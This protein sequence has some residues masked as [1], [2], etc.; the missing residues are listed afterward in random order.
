MK[1]FLAITMT[2][3]IV[4]TMSHQL[5]SQN[6]ADIKDFGITAGGFTNFPANQ[7]YMKDDISAF[8]VAPCVRSGRHEFSAGLLY[9]II[10]K[11]LSFSDNNI[12]PRPGFIAGYKFYILNPYYR[13]NVFI[14][15][16]FEYFRYTG[17]YDV[18]YSGNDVPVQ[19]TETDMYIN[20][21]IGLGY[22]LYFDTGQRFGLYYTLDYLIP[23]TSYK[24]GTPGYTNNSW[25][26]KY[27]WNNLSTHIGLSFKITSL[28]KKVRRLEGNV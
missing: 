8:Y 7:N 17:K 11:G 28:K 18:Y 19:W 1:K 21:V 24:L 25:T 13:E 5:L 14:H 9:P 15:Y 6:I 20:N 22:N 27:V 26:T 12:S 3:V 4:L 2:S 23:Q 16:S 10:T